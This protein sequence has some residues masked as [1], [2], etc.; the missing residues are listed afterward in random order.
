MRYVDLR[1]LLFIVIFLFNFGVGYC[2]RGQREEKLEKAWKAREHELLSAIVD[3]EIE[4]RAMNGL[5]LS[6]PIKSSPPKRR[7][8]SNGKRTD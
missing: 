7:E 1:V 3:L 5:I 8:K 2:A 6:K 4:C